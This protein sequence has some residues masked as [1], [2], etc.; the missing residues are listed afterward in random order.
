MSGIAHSRASADSITGGKGAP[1]ASSASSEGKRN[2]DGVKVKTRSVDYILRS[3][4]AG[5][6]AGCAVR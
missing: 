3:G 6:L 2:D 4:L 1:L 5:G